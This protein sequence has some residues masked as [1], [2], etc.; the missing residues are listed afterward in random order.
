MKMNSVTLII[1]ILIGVIGSSLICNAKLKKHG[2]EQY[3][4][5]YRSIHKELYIPA[6]YLTKKDLLVPIKKVN[7]KL[8]EKFKG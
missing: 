2:K 1:G 6:P 5:G 7:P 3:L 4:E 8:I